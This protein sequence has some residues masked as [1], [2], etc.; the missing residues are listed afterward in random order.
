MK[1][2]KINHKQK[3][4]PQI[5]LTIQRT[6]YSVW[7][8]LGFYKHHYLTSSLNKSAKCFLVQWNDTPIGFVALLPAPSNGYPNN[9]S[10][11]RLVILPDFQGLGLSKR[12]LNFVGGL[13]ESMTT[14]VDKRY[15]LYIKTAH[16][17]MG[18]SLSN[19]PNWCPTPKDGKSRNDIHNERKFKNR[20][21]RKSF[22]KKYIGQPLDDKYKH[23]MLPIK[24]LRQ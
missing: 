24:E 2:V 18:Q 9:M 6:E 1:Y 14:D 8:K 13:V 10:V 21:T 16:S 12:V 20:L 3:T 4:H 17:K 22:S 15:K 23:L 19:N 7:Y 11:S 5:E